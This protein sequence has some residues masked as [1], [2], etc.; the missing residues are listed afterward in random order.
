MLHLASHSSEAL[1]T[2]GDAFA[3]NLRDRLRQELARRH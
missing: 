1:G 2:F 3:R